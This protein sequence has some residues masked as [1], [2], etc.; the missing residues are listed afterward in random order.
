MM[1]RMLP[2]TVALALVLLVAVLTGGCGQK[3]AEEA[4]APPPAS[5]T[6][7]AQAPAATEAAETADSTTAGVAVHDC[8]GGCGM[9][10][11][12]EDQLTEIDGKWYCAGCAKKLQE[13]D[14]SGHG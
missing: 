12:P 14:H 11:V 6:Q 10:N 7:E 4:Q 13:E 3:E 2:L 5:T 8:A 1:R 9:T